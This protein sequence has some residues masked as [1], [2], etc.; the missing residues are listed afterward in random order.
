MFYGADVARLRS[1]FAEDILSQKVFYGGGDSGY[2]GTVSGSYT[3]P[4]LE[5]MV[6]RIKALFANN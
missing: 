2:L 5:S 4:E 6:A 1:L 3:A